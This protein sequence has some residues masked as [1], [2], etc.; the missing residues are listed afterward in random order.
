M[1]PV[2]LSTLS[3]TELMV[4]AEGYERKKA[5]QRKNMNR[6]YHK[7]IDENRVRA[8]NNAKKLYWRRKGYEIND[9]GEKIKMGSDLTIT[10][11]VAVQVIPD[12]PNPVS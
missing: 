11:I 2:D 10:D 8:K 9:L 3:L 5:S 7:Y 1:E 4:K 12:P 6:Y